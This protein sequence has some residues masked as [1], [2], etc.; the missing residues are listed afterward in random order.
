MKIYFLSSKPCELTLNGVFFGITDSFERFANVNLSDRIHAKFSP[1]DA[2]PIGVFLDDN[3]L[4]TPP[5]GV[6]VYI[7]QDGIALFAKDF[8]PNDYTLR[9][10]SQ[11]RLEN[12]LI[13]LYK[14]GE[15]HLSIQ[16]EKGFFVAT[17][18]P[19]SHDLP[20]LLTPC[21]LQDA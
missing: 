20:P 13:T 2:L 6:E 3:L 5:L 10:L 11:A 16:S 8:P 9:P 18:P 19:S 7:L 1:Q 15:I 21:P 4:H 14:Q 17:L 12:V